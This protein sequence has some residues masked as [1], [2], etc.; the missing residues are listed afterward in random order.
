MGDGRRRELRQTLG[1]AVFSGMIGVTA[2]GLIF[3]PGPS[4]SFAVAR[5]PRPESGNQR[6]CV[7]AKAILPEPRR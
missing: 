1:T 4:T 5:R 6:E 3:T 7:G 2:F